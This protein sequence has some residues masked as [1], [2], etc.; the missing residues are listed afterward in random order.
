MGW[1]FLHV[2]QWAHI[3][4]NTHVAL[5]KKISATFPLVVN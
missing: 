5:D 4:I 3:H 1:F 2:K